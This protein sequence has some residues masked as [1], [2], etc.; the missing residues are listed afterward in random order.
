MAELKRIPMSDPRIKVNGRTTAEREPLTVFWTAGGVELTLAASELWLDVDVDY[1][2]FDQWMT[3]EINGALISRTMLPKGRNTICLFRGVDAQQKRTVRIAKELQPMGDDDTAKLQMYAL[4]TDGELFETEERP[5]KIEFVGD[6]ITT[7]EGLAGAKCEMDWVSP[8][9]SNVGSYT[10]LTA[11]A[12]NA[13]FRIVSQSGWGVISA[14][15]NNTEHTLPAVYDAICGPL[16]GER[17]LALG[18]QQPNDFEAWRPDIVTIA[19]GANDWGGFN[20][21][22]WT[23]PDGTVHKLR[24]ESEGVPC[25]EDAKRFREGI[26]AFLAQVRARNPQAKIVWLGINEFC[27]PLV[28]HIRRAVRMYNRRTGDRVHMLNMHMRGEDAVGARMH[29]GVVAHR[30]F[31]DQLVP[32]LKKLLAQEK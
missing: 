18:A 12:L 11:D 29:P 17:G 3:V 9:F 6:S 24:L 25:E 23:A 16:Y 31:A 5:L 13:D 1:T 7:G 26:A 8:W 21:D 28:E 20:N 22:A 27:E 30:Q 2:A 19:L 32:F 4:L 15:D 10:H 14:F